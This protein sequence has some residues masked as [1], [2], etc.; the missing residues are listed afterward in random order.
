MA[1]PGIRYWEIA[2][3]LAKEFQVVLAAPDRTSLAHSD[4]QVVTYPMDHPEVLA[5]RARQ[6]DVV[7]AY[8]YTVGQM[9]FLTEIPTPW[10]ADVYVPEP[11]EVLGFQ[12]GAPLNQREQRHGQVT[13]ALDALARRADF[14]I[15]ANERQRDFWLGVLAAYG[16]LSPRE[17]TIDP[18]LRS[19][20]DV[21]PF[22]LPSTP[23]VHRR[24]AIKGV[25]P[26]IQADDRV[27]LWGG[28]LWDWLDPLTLLRAL[29]QVIQ[30]QPRTRLVFPGTRHPNVKQVPDMAMRQRMEALTRELDLESHVFSGNWLPYSE[31]ENYLLEA[32]V[33]ASLHADTIETRFAFRT[34]ILDYIWAGLPMVVTSG[35]SLS[36]WVSRYALGQVVPPNDEG[37]VAEA[38]LRLL[39]VQDLRGAYQKRFD[40]VRRQFTW[41]RVCEPIVRFC[42]EPSSPAAQLGT[43]RSAGLDNLSCSNVELEAE[44][45]RLRNLVAAYEEGRFMRLMRQVHTWREKAG[46]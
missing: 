46:F 20:V 9:P 8:G 34:R 24:P 16:R 37:V 44:V 19:L 21:V 38:L 14:Y 40:Q 3:V 30:V 45:A 2:R 23:P 10:I 13:R 43:T 29:A 12:P 26:G 27:V 22:G 11:T 6:A 15:C 5:G 17:Y 33:G 36:E 25:W 7:L 35:D 18:T 42:R 31:R 1:G 39:K 32:D 4:F 41:E 28:G